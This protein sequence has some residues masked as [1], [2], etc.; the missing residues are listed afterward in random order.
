MSILIPTSI[1]SLDKD[2]YRTPDISQFDLTL[3]EY[4]ITL[5]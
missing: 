3:V 1:L 5:H 2:G 4:Q